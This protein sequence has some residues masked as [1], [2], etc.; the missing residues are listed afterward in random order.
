MKP[1]SG[2]EIESVSHP[3]PHTHAHLSESESES[4]ATGSQCQ[5]FQRATSK[6]QKLI[7]PSKPQLVV[8]EDIENNGDGGDGTVMAQ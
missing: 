8:Y 5:R 6:P 1:H 3:H 2:M 7:K 4:M